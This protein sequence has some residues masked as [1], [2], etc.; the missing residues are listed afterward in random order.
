MNFE[1][2]KNDPLFA[3][4]AIV[5]GLPSHPRICSADRFHSSQ[6]TQLWK[7]EQKSEGMVVT[8]IET[9]CKV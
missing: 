2:V 8:I 4:P 3:I 1:D 9:T 5:I 7:P 6:I